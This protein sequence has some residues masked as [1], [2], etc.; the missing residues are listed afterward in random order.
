MA[1]IHTQH[2][3]TFENDH[4][5]MIVRFITLLC[6][7]TEGTLNASDSF[8]TAFR[9]VKKE[10]QILS[11]LAHSQLVHRRRHQRR[12]YIEFNQST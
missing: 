12:R 4:Q 1:K 11:D 5:K 9:I 6:I 10:V 2:T 7:L 3:N 8:L